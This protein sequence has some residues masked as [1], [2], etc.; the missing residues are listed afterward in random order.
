MSSFLLSLFDRSPY[1]DGKTV[2]SINEPASQEQS[3]HEVVSN[4][5][6]ED[7]QDRCSAAQSTNEPPSQEQSAVNLI[8]GQYVLVCCGTR[9]FPAVVVRIDEGDELAWVRF[10][11]RNSS[12]NWM[13]GDVDYQILP[14]DVI[15]LMQAPYVVTSKR[16]IEYKFP[17]YK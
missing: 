5:V 1:Q 2:Q 17:D 12:R 10:Y 7:L 15:R 14:E 16:S 8:V 6:P 3:S 11:T 9:C 13:A 4:S